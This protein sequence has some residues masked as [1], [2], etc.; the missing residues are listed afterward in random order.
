MVDSMLQVDVSLINKT[1][2]LLGCKVWNLSVGIW[3]TYLESFKE[4]LVCLA[5]VFVIVLLY[6][7]KC[8][9]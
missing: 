9:S 2:L 1:Y 5:A 7:R 4:T 3:L 6:I 8:L